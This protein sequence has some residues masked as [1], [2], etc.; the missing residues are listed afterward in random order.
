MKTIE[1][2]AEESAKKA[3]GELEGLS[4]IDGEFYYQHTEAFKAGVEFAQRWIPVEEELPDFDKTKY[5]NGNYEVHLVKMVTG[6]M[7]PITRYAVSHLINETRWSCEFDWSV[8]THW[9]PIEY[10]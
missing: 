4:D 2:A 6:G 7:S 1:E 3:F 5:P 9:R 10:K 8:V